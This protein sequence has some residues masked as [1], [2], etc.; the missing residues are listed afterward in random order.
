MTTSPDPI[1]YVDLARQNAGLIDD[2]MGRIRRVLEHG[3]SILGPEVAELE[4]A[5]ARVLGVAHV[6]GVN[7]GTDALVLALASHGI[8]PGDEVVTPS[9]TFLA[10]ASA[11]CAVGA[12]PV[13]AD[14]DPR[15]MVVS[16]ETL[17]AVLSPR[18]RA[19]IPVH[20][21][22]FPC[23]MPAIMAL[24]RRRD[25][26]VL[27]DTAQA[28]GAKRD[29][30]MAG[31]FG[32]GCFSLHPLKV[33][34]ACG[35]AGFIA[36]DDDAR[37]DDLR[38]RRNIGLR[39]RDEAALVSTN[40]RLDTLQAAILLGKLPYLE[41][42]I[43]RRN[44][45]ARHYREALAGLATM[46][47]EEASVR[48]IY[49]PFVL[50]IEEGRDG[51]RKRLADAGIDTR[52]HYPIPVHRQAPYR[53]FATGPLPAT[54]RLVETILSLPCSPELSEDQRDRVIERLQAELE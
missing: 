11:V 28:L 25:L 23:D 17:E 45:H 51:L 38:Q 9:H 49:T 8:G 31:T 35:D 30:R 39:N 22:G 12:T 18:T 20:L 34:G 32:T 42:W 24:A 2:L 43:A 1:A 10:T 36:T 33:L 41:T 26:V 3:Q 19:V 48:A 7:S 16:A 53:R 14:V 37:A 15:T 46:P 6:I 50:R 29:G 27:E 40:S 52:V 13:F 21:N 54:E 5:L 47:P 4:T 44:D